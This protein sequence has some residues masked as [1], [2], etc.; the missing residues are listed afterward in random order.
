MKAHGDWGK[1]KTRGSRM[2]GNQNPG[3]SFF[4]VFQ[5]NSFMQLIMLIGGKLNLSLRTL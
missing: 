1:K 4:T 5:W 2:R 3:G